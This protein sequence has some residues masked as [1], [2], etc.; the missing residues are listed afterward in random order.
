LVLIPGIVI[1]VLAT[2][3]NVIADGLRDALGRDVGVLAGPKA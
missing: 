2:A 1:T 3:F